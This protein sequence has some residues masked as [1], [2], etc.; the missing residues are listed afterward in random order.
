MSNQQENQQNTKT[1][2]K[3]KKFNE[4]TT[5]AFKIYIKILRTIAILL[6]LYFFIS[7]YF[8]K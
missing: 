3:D 4:K 1:G 5:K 7:Y 6:V 2:K 8:K